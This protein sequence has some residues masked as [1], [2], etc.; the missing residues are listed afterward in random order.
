[1]CMQSKTG[2]RVTEQDKPQHSQI[3]GLGQRRELPEAGPK[4]A[5]K[6][7]VGT[8][9]VPQKL[10]VRQSWRLDMGQDRGAGDVRSLG[11][12]PQEC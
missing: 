1:M 3:T 12:E 10:D 6:A 7:E 2:T 8:G 4:E 11:Q 9:L 5:V